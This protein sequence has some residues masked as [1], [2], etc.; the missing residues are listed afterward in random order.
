MISWALVSVVTL[1]IVVFVIGFVCG[2]DAGRRE[3]KQRAVEASAL[4][5]ATVRVSQ[6]QLRSRLCDVNQNRRGKEVTR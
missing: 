5:A 3:G 2:K 1:A 4:R 6:Q